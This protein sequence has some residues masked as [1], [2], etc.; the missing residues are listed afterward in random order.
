VVLDCARADEQSG[1]DLSVGLS[2]GRETSDLHLLC[3]GLV[4][5]DDRTLLGVL[6]GGP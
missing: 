6:A 5:R 3:S 1:S 2:G 4:E